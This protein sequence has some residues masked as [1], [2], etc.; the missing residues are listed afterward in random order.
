MET[1]MTAP[2]S[3][4]KVEPT[5]NPHADAPKPAAPAP[6]KVPAPE[7]LAVDAPRRE[8]PDVGTFDVIGAGAGS[9]RI[10]SDYWFLSERERVGY[11][12]AADAKARELGYELPGMES[13]GR[14]PMGA[15]SLDSFDYETRRMEVLRRARDENPDAF[16]DVPFTQ[17]DIMADINTRLKA[18]WQDAQDTLNAA[19]D[20]F[21]SRTVPEFI[22]RMAVGASDETNAAITLGT[23]GVGASAS[24]GRMVL[25]DSALSVVGEAATMPKRFDMAERLDI[26]KPNV[27]VE[28]AFAA[29]VGAAIP[30]GIRGVQRGAQITN[31]E[32][33]KQLRKRASDL[34]PDE[35]AAVNAV[36]RELAEQDVG[37]SARPKDQPGAVDAALEDIDA[38]LP[39]SN[40]IPTPDAA[41]VA[42]L[43][44]PPPAPAVKLEFDLGP[45]RPYAPDQ[46]VLDVVTSAVEDVLGRGSRVVVTSGQEGDLP[47]HGS[48]RHQ[49]GGAADI[50]VYDADGT[51]INMADHPEIMADIARA[52]ASRGAKGIGFGSEYMGGRHMHIDLLD[53]DPAQGQANTWA[54]GG[55]AM[56]DE[57]VALMNGTLT[58][59]KRG[60]PLSLDESLRGL[61]RDGEGSGYD[62]PSDFTIIA[63][64]RPLPEMTLDEIDAWQAANQQA[65]AES[66]A[67]GGYQIIRD[68]LLGLRADLGLTGAEKFDDAMQDR[69]ANALL[70]QAGLSRFQ[71]G[72]LSADGFADNLAG[73]WASL[74]MADGRSR[75]AGDGLNAA[76]VARDTVLTVLGGTPYQSRGRPPPSMSR[77]PAAGIQVDARTYQFRSNVN[78]D[79]VG[80]AMG[81]VNEWDELLAGDVIVHERLDGGRYIADGHHRIDLSRRLESQGHAPIELNGFILREDD[82]Y[83]VEQVRA[84]A[85]VKNIEAGN[86]SALDAAKVLR[87]DPALLEKLTLRNSHARDARGLMRLSDDGLDMVT[88]GQVAEP[89]AAFVG[90]LTS[91]GQMQDAILRTLVQAKPRSLAE[92]RQIAQDAYRAGRVKQDAG[93]QTSLFG[94]D[95]DIGETLFKERSEVLARALAQLRS[96]K[97]VFA[98]LVRERDRITEAGNE[99]ADAS[100][101]ARVTTDE[102]ALALIE[103]LVNRA[104]PLDDALN[105]AARTARSNTT[106]A[107]VRDFL[108]TVRQAVEGGD[109]GR[110]LDG[111]DGS[112]RNAAPSNG[113]A[114]EGNPSRGQTDGSEVGP[115]GEEAPSQAGRQG[116]GRATERTDVGEQTLIDGVAPI[117]DRDRLQSAQ[118]APLRGGAA[119]ADGGLFDM[120]ARD[121]GDMFAAD[122]RLGD[123]FDNPAP[124]SPAVAAQLDAADNELRRALAEEGD[125]FLP[126]GRIVDGEAEVISAGDILADLDADDNFLEILNV[127]KR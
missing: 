116:A 14:S 100:N 84:I 80:D 109:I 43:T 115:A 127:C 82:G 56:R 69:L 93:A 105:T 27:G 51:E 75:Y 110:L 106:A 13:T 91:D 4:A 94:D 44:T 77:F 18:E 6:V 31:R 8:A 39:P 65:G 119:Q 68:T 50:R 99:V 73:V 104:G 54:S 52:A 21:W 23:L 34:A 2:T 114:D 117:T 19:P 125:L 33:V 7:G 88:N 49:T 57:L 92:A 53:P 81:R 37:P 9:E 63:P 47:Q 74:P 64:P 20:G 101:A 58:L 76:H 67:A 46:P 87:V 36:E 122:A 26:A 90:E 102:T 45:S 60:A 113:R 120:G 41:R 32:L 89:H 17:D 85:A 40:D 1:G 3:G 35:R 118:D 98:T 66:T 25:V 29:T 59:P 28:L 107:G 38:G 15:M 16:K 11:D 108:A 48:D 24:L 55:A 71:S 42:S 22:G 121:Q 112:P 86:A 111:G 79:G 123:A 30:L 5:P 103:K 124:D 78:A 61:L 126:T 70:E 95:F 72:E 10:E 62:T 83:T 96:D 12:A 97:R